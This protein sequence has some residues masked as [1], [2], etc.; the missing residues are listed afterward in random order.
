[1]K[2]FRESVIQ[3]LGEEYKKKDGELKVLPNGKWYGNGHPEGKEYSHILPD[4]KDRRNIL[5][6]FRDCFYKSEQSKPKPE[7]IKYHRFFHHLNSSQAMCINFFFPLIKKN[8]LDVILQALNITDDKVDYTTVAFEKESDIEKEK[9]YRPTNFDFYFE[10]TNNKK[11]YFEIKYTE[12][13]FGKAKD[14]EEHEKKY[15]D[16]YCEA[17]KSK[18]EENTKSCFLGHYQLMRNLIHVSK[19]DYV[20]FVVPEQNESVYKQ[21]KDAEIF[22]KKEFRENV[23]ILTWDTLYKNEYINNGELK[24]YYET[25]KKKYVIYDNN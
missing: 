3:Y 8:K 25:F 19:N 22:V 18:I 11:F 4:K 24:L 16:V 1:M 14:D 2:N 10:T 15:T 23:K 12:E 5:K 13:G 6:E 9:G 17:A 21:V 20:V 7:K